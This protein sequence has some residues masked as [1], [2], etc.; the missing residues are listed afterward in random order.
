MSLDAPNASTFWL[1]DHSVCARVAES[2]LHFSVPRSFSHSSHR[3]RP[4]V[5]DLNQP[6]AAFFRTKSGVMG[7]SRSGSFLEGSS[8][9]PFLFPPTSRAPAIEAHGPRCP[10]SFLRSHSLPPGSRSSP[11]PILAESSH[12]RRLEEAHRRARSPPNR[13]SAISPPPQCVFF[14]LRSGDDPFF[15]TVAKRL[16]LGPAAIL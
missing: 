3:A 12:A 4:S 16:L 9:P 11:I 6:Q 10:R 1:H 2:S 14:L 8:P 13:T 15:K 7:A 5:F